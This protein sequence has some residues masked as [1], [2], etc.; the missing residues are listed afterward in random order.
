VSGE[1]VDRYAVDLA[2]VA[3]KQLVP[4]RIVAAFNLIYLPKLRA[5]GRPGWSRRAQLAPIFSLGPKLGIF[6]AATDWV[7]TASRATAVLLVQ[8]YM[9]SCPSALGYCLPGVSRS[10]VGRWTIAAY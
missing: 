9:P 7:S 4:N 8:Q 2:L 6:A 1:P 3:D 10:R 5:R